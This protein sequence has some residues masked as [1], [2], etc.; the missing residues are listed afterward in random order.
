MTLQENNHIAVVDLATGKVVSNFSAG[1]VDL[2][3]IDTKKDGVIS[4]T[5]KIE[6]R[7]ASPTPCKWLDD[8]RFVTANEGDWKGGSRGF[9]I[10]NEGRHGRFRHRHRHSS[11][12]PCASATIPTSATRRA[13]KSEGAEVATFGADKLIFVGAERASVVGVYKD[14]GRRQG[15]RHSCRRCRAASDRKACSPSRSAICS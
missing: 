9:T 6:R 2:E 8:D 13:A 4:L 7:C 5:G 3:K 14:E 15:P 10:F 1:A 11:M 12:R